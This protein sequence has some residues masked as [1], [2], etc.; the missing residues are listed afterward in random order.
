MDED[1]MLTTIDNPYDPFTEFESWL[2]YDEQNGYF[3]NGLIARLTLDS[4]ELTEKENELALDHA[5]EDILNLFPGLYIRVWRKEKT[6][7]G[8]E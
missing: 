3:T 8:V 5:V 6:R 4:N 2:A 7:E 1:Y